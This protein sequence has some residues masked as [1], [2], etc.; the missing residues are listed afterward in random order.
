M[1][2]IFT[3]YA[4]SE[5]LIIFEIKYYFP[6]EKN[7]MFKIWLFFNLYLEKSLLSE[8][9]LANEI[10]NT[11][12]LTPSLKHNLKSYITELWLIYFCVWG[13]KHIYTAIIFQINNKIT[14]FFCQSY[15]LLS[16]FWISWVIN[17]NHL[18]KRF[19]YSW[20]FK[21]YLGIFRKS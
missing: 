19:S 21:L 17:Q 14:F 12:Y 16:L 6:W 20:S 9:S 5:I 13:T 3:F 2:F 10:S 1:I 4:T 11:V 8:S 15:L 18:L 7:N